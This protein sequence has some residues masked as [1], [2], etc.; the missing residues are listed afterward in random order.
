MAALPP[1]RGPLLP[2]AW[3]RYQI[4]KSL[5]Q[6]DRTR[7]HELALIWFSKPYRDSDEGFRDLNFAINALEAAYIQL[8]GEPDAHGRFF[9]R[10]RN[11]LGERGIKVADYDMCCAC[12]PVIARCS[13]ARGAARSRRSRLPCCV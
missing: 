3:V 12:A 4:R 1:A 2:Q 11:R 9:P 10:M 13:V 6:Q 8:T 7:A 5:K